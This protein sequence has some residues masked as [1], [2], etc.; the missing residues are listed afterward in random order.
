MWFKNKF[1]FVHALCEL[2]LT[3]RAL[4]GSYSGI[5]ADEGFILTQASLIKDQGKE[6]IMDKPADSQSFCQEVMHLTAAL[7]SL[8]K[9]S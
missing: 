2:Y 5:G 4:C 8:A 3:K 1:I 9:T 6:D 7:F